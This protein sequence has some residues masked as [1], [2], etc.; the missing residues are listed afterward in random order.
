M[1]GRANRDAG[2]AIEKDVAVRI[3]DPYALRVI[4]DEFVIGSGIARGDVQSIGVNDR[5]CF[6]SWKL[7]LD[8]RFLKFGCRCHEFL[9][10]LE[11]ASYRV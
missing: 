6:R 1:P 3:G 4:G 7:G 5:L 2:V 11:C 10:G 9:L 8:Y